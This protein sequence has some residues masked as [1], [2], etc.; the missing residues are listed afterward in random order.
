MPNSHFRT[1][2]GLPLPWLHIPPRQFVGHAEKN[3]KILDIDRLVVKESIAVLARTPHLSALDVNISASSFDDP[4]LPAYISAELH[5]AEVDPR[6]LLVEL[7]E[8]SAAS[9]LRDAERFINALQRM[10]C[11]VC[12]DDFGTGFSSFAF[13]KH[14]KADV[15]KI[16]GLFIHSL[17]HEFDSQVFVRAIIEVAR[18]LE[19]KTAAEFVESQEILEML[20]S[21]DV[22]MVQGYHLDQPQADH[23]ALAGERL[24]THS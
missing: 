23:P 12:V 18:G 21:F 3:G 20:K 7:T 5:A 2:S 19:M 11:H 24:L 1:P 13:L 22:D 16:N 4:D 6:R 10:G 14:L 15:L 17:S 9:D 8:T